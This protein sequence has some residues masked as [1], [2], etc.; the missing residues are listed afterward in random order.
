MCARRIGPAYFGSSRRA[1][2]ALI[3][4]GAGQSQGCQLDRCRIPLELS[5]AVCLQLSRRGGAYLPRRQ[6]AF[7]MAR[8]G[9]WPSR[10][11]RF[12]TTVLAINLLG[13]WVRGLA[14]SQAASPGCR[15]DGSYIGRIGS[16]GGIGR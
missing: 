3:R 6:T 10:D 2:R 13:D 1:R 14:R 4:L 9:G 5:L 15:L 7:A 11:L 8:P 12:M 16:S